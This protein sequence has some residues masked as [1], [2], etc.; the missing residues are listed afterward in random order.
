M[1]TPTYVP[2]P[3]I[4]G[5]LAFSVP[6]RGLLEELLDGAA[7]PNLPDDMP[8]VTRWPRACRGLPPITSRFWVMRSKCGVAAALSGMLGIV[9]S[10]SRLP[11][12]ARRVQYPEGIDAARPWDLFRRFGEKSVRNALDRTCR[13]P[14]P[15]A[16]GVCVT[17]T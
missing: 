12:R 7:G 17:S 14:R 9:V 13:T 10:L 16:T 3:Y 5:F 6:S 8:T 1:R 4:R 2:L 15:P 11:M